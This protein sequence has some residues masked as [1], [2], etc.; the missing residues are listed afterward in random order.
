MFVN[1]TLVPTSADI[2]WVYSEYKDED[3]FLYLKY[4]LCFSLAPYGI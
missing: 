2:G 4:A 1:E 3:G